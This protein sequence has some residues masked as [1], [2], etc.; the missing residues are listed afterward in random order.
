[1]SD[2]IIT[3]ALS[4]YGKLVSPIKQ[5]PI[6]TDSPLLKHIVSFRR[7]VYMVVQDDAVSDLSLK[8]HI[9]GFEY[10]IFVTT[11]KTKC[12]GCWKIEHLIKRSG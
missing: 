8:F 11:A 3:Q 12:F 2:D 5:I 7:F 4:L 10:V 9:D 1:M 6:S